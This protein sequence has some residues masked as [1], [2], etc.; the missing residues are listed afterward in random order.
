VVVCRDSNTVKLMY[1]KTVFCLTSALN[2][3]EEAHNVLYIKKHSMWATPLDVATTPILPPYTRKAACLNFGM[4]GRVLD[5]INHAKSE[6]DLFGVSEPQVVENRKSLSPIDWR[7]RPFNSVRIN[8]LHCD[9]NGKVVYEGH[10]VNVK[11]QATLI[12]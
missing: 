5:I 4:W 6:L 3:T 12:S 7:Y 10:R 1:A 8:V 2:T 9:I 11:I